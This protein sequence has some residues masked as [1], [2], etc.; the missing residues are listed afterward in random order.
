MDSVL[1]N[2]FYPITFVNLVWLDV[3]FAA[4]LKLANNARTLLL[5]SINCVGALKVSILHQMLAL[6][7]HKTV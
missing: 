5:K 3:M 2:S 6:L 1:L 4:T 7:A